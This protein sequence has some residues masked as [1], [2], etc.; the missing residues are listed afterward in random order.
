M[1]DKEREI[2][3]LKIEIAWHESILKNRR[4]RLAKAIQTKE[5]EESKAA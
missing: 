3:N 1:S 4:E 5:I 2:Q